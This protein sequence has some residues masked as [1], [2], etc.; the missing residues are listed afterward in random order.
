LTQQARNLCMDL[1]DTAQ[2]L[3]A[4]GSELADLA[5]FQLITPAPLIEHA[6]RRVHILPGRAVAASS[7]WCYPSAGRTMCAAFL[8]CMMFARQLEFAAHPRR[9]WSWVSAIAG[10]SGGW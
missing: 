9:S 1:D 7:C 2:R 6:T 3:A 10:G 5:R 4:P 8:A